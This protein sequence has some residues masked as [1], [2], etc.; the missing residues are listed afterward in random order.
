MNINK[1]KAK[2]DE[3]PPVVRNLPQLVC[4]TA[5][6]SFGREKKK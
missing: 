5:N 6:I 2:R 3:R 4:D 1:L